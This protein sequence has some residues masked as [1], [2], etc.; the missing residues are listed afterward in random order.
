TLPGRARAVLSG[1]TFAPEVARGLPTAVT[2]AALDRALAERLAGLLGGTR[3]R[4]YVSTDPVGAEIGGAVKNVLAIACGIAVGRRLGDNA[5]AALITRGLAEM[6]RFALAL[7]G[8][9]ETMMGL[10][11]LGDLVL[12][13]TS[14]QSRNYALGA[15]LGAGTTLADALAGKRSIAEGVASAGAVVAR[16][17]REGVEMPIAAA[18]D[19]VLNRGAPIDAVVGALLARPFRDETIE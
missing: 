10:S 9:A 2:L 3:F 8:R 4:P 7:G 13:C 14:A 18:V 16:A 19:A 15:A 5:R 1:P 11:G 12:T 6:T 17:A